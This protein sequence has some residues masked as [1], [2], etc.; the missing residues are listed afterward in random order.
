MKKRVKNHNLRSVVSLPLYITT[1][2][3]VPARENLAVSAGSCNKFHNKIILFPCAL[4]GK[5]S[6]GFIS[7]SNFVQ[8]TNNQ[9]GYRTK[10]HTLLMVYYLVD[11]Y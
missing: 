11:G 3:K 2:K 5:R 9:S 4:A 6:A 10:K 8:I 7:G 1:E